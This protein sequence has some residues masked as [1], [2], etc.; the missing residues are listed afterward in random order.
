MISLMSWTLKRVLLTLLCSM[1]WSLIGWSRFHKNIYNI[2]FVFSYQTMP[3]ME[4]KQMILEHSVREL[5][6]EEA[7]IVKWCEFEYV[8]R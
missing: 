4:M 1:V 3:T 6:K 7:G 5:I 2:I 8:A